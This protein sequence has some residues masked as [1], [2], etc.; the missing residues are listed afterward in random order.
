[1]TRNRTVVPALALLLGIVAYWG[2]APMPAYA[3]PNTGQG[4]SIQ[5]I[6]RNGVCETYEVCVWEHNNYQ[7]GWYDYLAAD[8]DFRNDY[9]FGNGLSVDNRI[10][11][12]K[13]FDPNCHANFFRHP[14]Y[15]GD[16]FAAARSTSPGSQHSSLPFDN[17]RFSSMRWQC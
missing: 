2:I 7:G 12:V 3:G 11:S 1:M 16:T 5:S 13:N 6:G 17:D 15:T 4:P 10:S 8:D 9:F 14:G